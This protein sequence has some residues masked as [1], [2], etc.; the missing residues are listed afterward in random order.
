[1]RKGTAKG[2]GEVALGIGIGLFV[3]GL[4][5]VSVPVK[6]E[7]GMLSGLDPVWNYPY[8]DQ[9]IVVLVA[10]NILVIAGFFVHAYSHRIATGDV[11]VY[12]NACGKLVPSDSMS[13]RYCGHRLG[14]PRADE[15]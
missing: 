2:V 9:G 8:R 10:S 12:C 7:F 6:E 4:L 11:G 13:C 1:M 15:K 14:A 5:L 3:L